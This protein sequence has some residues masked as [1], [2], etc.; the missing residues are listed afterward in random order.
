MTASGVNVVAFGPHPDDAELFC[1]GTLVRMRDL[2]YSTGIVDL[3]RGEL[4][5][6]GT[7]EIRAREA[8]AAGAVLGLSFRENL[9]LPDGAL[10][11]WRL[12]DVAKVVEVIRRRR[13]EIVLAPWT[14]ARHPDHA[15]AGELVTKAVFW[16]G[17]TKFSTEPRRDRFT[18]H[19][20]LYYPMRYTFIPSLVVNTTGAVECKRRAILCHAS[21]VLRSRDAKPTLVNA[22]N[23]VDSLLARDA[24]YGAMIGTSYGEPF[25]TSS[26][27][28]VDDPVAHFRANPLTGAAIF[29]VQR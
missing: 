6:N 21:Q 7:P 18:V 29:A 17:V 25:K 16:A 8:E 20:V 22:V 2:G 4:A 15:A 5:T 27:L 3:T 11:P 10:N 14:E 26:P 19:Q 1:G 23:A 12:A 28:A 13:P 24:H 9:G